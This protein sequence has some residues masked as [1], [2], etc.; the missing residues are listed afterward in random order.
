MR[1]DTS[2][3]EDLLSPTGF[4]GSAQGVSP[5]YN[6]GSCTTN[7]MPASATPVS[8]SGTV[9]FNQFN[10][11]VLSDHGAVTTRCSW[12]FGMPRRVP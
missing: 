9:T 2:T 10:V 4:W 7:C 6:Y 3:N 8:G 1:P 5:D 12:T 11:E